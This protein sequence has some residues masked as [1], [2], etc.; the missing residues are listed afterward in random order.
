MS[1]IRIWHAS[2][3]PYHCAFRMLRLLSA[4][5]GDRMEL[6]RLRI[7]DL[8]LLYPP[9][10]HAASMPQEVRASFRALEVP[11]PEETFIRLPSA[12]A[13]SQDLR[14]YQNAALSHLAARRMLK[15]GT[16]REGVAELDRTQVPKDIS[17][18]AESKNRSDGGFVAFLTRDFARI[19]LTGR[20]N[21]YRRASLPARTM[22]P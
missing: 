9:L 18:R 14:L 12:A 19:P 17:S 1:K 16:L 22:T 3:D 15:T 2:R 21:V 13:I 4:A 20:E 10:L 7:L 5:D 6:E 11:R 8:Y